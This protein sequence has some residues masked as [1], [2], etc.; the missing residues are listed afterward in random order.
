MAVKQLSQEQ[1]QYIK[2]YADALFPT[3]YLCERVGVCHLG[4]SDAIRSHRYL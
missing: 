4:Y 1:M 2:G 3:Q